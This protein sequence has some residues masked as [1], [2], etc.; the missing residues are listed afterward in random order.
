MTP[1]FYPLLQMC[2]ENGLMLGWN[3]AH[4]HKDDPDPSAIHDAQQQAI[5]SVIHEWFDFP[6][7]PD[8]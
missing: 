5:M 3:R 8:A 4:K 2:V 6:D 1:K 7:P